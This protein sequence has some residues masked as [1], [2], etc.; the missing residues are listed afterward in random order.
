MDYAAEHERIKA[1]R[2]AETRNV[3]AAVIKAGYQNVRVGHGT[4][5]AFGWL[6]IRADRKSGLTYEETNLDLIHIAQAVTGR[7]GDYDGRIGTDI[8]AEG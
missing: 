2:K 8:C 1:E 4:G 7:S 5:T 6:H 3:K